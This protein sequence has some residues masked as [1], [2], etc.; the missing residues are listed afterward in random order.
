VKVGIVT[1]SMS[2]L[3][4]ELANKYGIIVVPGIVFI[5]GKPYKSG[6]DI[7]P[8]DIEGF[9][10]KNKHKISTG[11]PSAA[12]YHKVY[13]HLGDNVDIILSIHSSSK[14]TATSTIAKVA[15]KRLEDP[16]QVVQLECGVGSLGLG[17]TAIAAAIITKQ[18][19]NLSELLQRVMECCKRIQIIG[20][21]A[22]LMYLQRSGRVKLKIA[23]FLANTFS[24]KPVLMMHGDNISLLEKS[25]NRQ[26]A[27]SLMVESV[28]NLIDLNFD[29]K[30][31]GI[32][33]FNCA[34][35]AKEVKDII[36]DNFP[37]HEII[38]G[39]IDPMIAAYTGPG[40]ILLSFFSTLTNSE[41]GVKIND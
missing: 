15:A 9:I 25:R 26:R 23:G 22:S 19:N 41:R 36:K 13:T 24:I 3:P 35:E 38:Q 20:T 40:L 7:F 39:N 6:I 12:E 29:P 37:D 2:D 8:N 18:A 31:V 30:L 10:I 17:L 28:F 4:P 5:D 34:E 16:T 33:H 14:V 32:G 21:L 27:I 1:D 11:A